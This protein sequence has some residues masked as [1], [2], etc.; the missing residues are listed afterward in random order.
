MTHSVRFYFQRITDLHL[1]MN[2][3]HTNVP[4]IA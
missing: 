4:Q 3:V 2:V 1:F